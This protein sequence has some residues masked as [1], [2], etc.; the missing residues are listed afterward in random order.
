LPAGN[1][2]L[3]RD[4]DDLRLG[5]VLVDR[6][7]ERLE[8]VG[9]LLRLLA[10]GEVVVAGVQDDDTRLV[11]D[12]EAVSEVD[13]IRELRAAEA[14]IDVVLRLKA[15]LQLPHADAGTADEDNAVL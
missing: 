13:G 9:D 11:L 1:A 4:V 5:Q 8:V 14:A 10:R 12:D 3:D 15:V 2:R 6:L 7:D